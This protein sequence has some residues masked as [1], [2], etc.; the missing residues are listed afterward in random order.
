MSEPDRRDFLTTLSL[1]GLAGLSAPA[2]A[3]SVEASPATQESAS[4]APT[5]V[6]RTLARYVLGVKYEDLPPAVRKEAQRT[7]LNWV[8]CAVGGSRHE[9]R[10]CGARRARA[11]LRAAAGD[12][13]RAAAN[14]W[15]SCTPR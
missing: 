3:A 11:V 6:T 5:D 14:A 10:G 7:L 12:G 1:A 13:A 15:T 8:G 9:T 2:A 4:A